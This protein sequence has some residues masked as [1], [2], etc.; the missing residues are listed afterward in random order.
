MTWTTDASGTKTPTV[1]GT[2]TISNASPG[3]VSITNTAAAGDMVVFTTT[4]TLPTGLSPNTIYYIISTGLSGS[5]F[6]VSATAGG[7]AINTSSAGSGTHTA[8]IEHVL[9]QP[10]TVATYVFDADLDPLQNG[11]LVELRCYDM[12][13]GTHYRQIFKAAFQHAQGSH[14]ANNVGM[15]A[16]KKSP[17]F[18]VLTQAQFT[19]KQ[20]AGTARAIPWA[21]RRI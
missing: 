21:V 6:E 14:A 18:P 8:T 3:V 13:D 1:A 12:I 5:Q 7:A 10:T 4:G 11:D 20:L 17:P 16:G 19:I 15:N 2:C 9:D